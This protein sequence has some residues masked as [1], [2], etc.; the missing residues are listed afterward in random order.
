MSGQELVDLSL[1]PSFR[2]A[3]EHQRIASL[4]Y[5]V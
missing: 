1:L 3:E 5:V 2:F 4:H